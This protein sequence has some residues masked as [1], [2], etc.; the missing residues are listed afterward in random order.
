MKSYFVTVQ[1]KLFT[2]NRSVMAD[3]KA[4]AASK[5]DQDGALWVSVEESCFDEE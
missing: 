4:E 2:I 1:A 5:V 3:G